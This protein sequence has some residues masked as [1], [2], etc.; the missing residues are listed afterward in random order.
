[1][2]SPT[3]K[4]KLTDKDTHDAA[5]ER[6]ASC[7]P[8]K[9]SGYECTTEVVLDVLIKAAATQQTIECVCSDL[10]GVVTGETIRSHRPPAKPVA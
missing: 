5:M 6:L 4:L 10:D 9:V 8:L 2:T 1:M 3:A 7:L